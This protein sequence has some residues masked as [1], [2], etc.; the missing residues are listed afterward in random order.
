MYHAQASSLTGVTFAATSGTHDMYQDTHVS[1]AVCD[2]G[3]GRVIS[4]VDKGASWQVVHEFGH[5]VTMVAT[6]PTRPHTLYAAV[7]DTTTG[8]QP[9][10]P[11][12]SFCLKIY[13]LQRQAGT[14]FHSIKRSR[15][16]RERRRIVSSLPLVCVC[17]AIFYSLM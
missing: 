17:I 7:V 1:P 12:P 2:K 6:S 10:F 4:T 9:A 5:P 11:C 15:E 14:K 8:V 3:E 13:H 16:P